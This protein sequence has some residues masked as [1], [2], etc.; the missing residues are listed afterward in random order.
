MISFLSVI[1]RYSSSSS[2]GG[3]KLRSGIIMAAETEVVHDLEIELE[4]LPGAAA[5]DA[6]QHGGR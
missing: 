6:S 4:V 5:N 3:L 2:C 1:F